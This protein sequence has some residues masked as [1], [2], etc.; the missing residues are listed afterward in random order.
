MAMPT[1]TEL[2]DGAVLANYSIPVS[3]TI[4]LSILVTDRVPQAIDGSPFLVFS[5]PKNPPVVSSAQLTESFG[6]ITVAFDQATNRGGVVG[7]TGNCDVLLQKV[8][9]DL[10]GI[11][12]E[13]LWIDDFQ[14]Q[15]LM[16][17]NPTIKV[18]DLVLLNSFVVV[19]RE[20]NS[21]A[22]SGVV[23]LEAPPPPLPSPVAVIS[24][25][26]MVSGD[27]VDGDQDDNDGEC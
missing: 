12:P 20:E 11:G 15:G 6:A 19:N 4:Y 25:P 27:H 1:L 5:T 24:A 2:G 21:F 16:G 3:G 7:T 22:A 9:V 17:S 23:S 13:C 14:F 10:M 8:T 26:M 18:A